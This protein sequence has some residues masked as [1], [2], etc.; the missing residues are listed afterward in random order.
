MKITKTLPLSPLL[1]SPFLTFG[2]FLGILSGC[3]TEGEPRLEALDPWARPMMIREPGGRA[4]G[5]NSAVYLALRNS[6][7]APDTLL[8][9]ETPV[10][11]AVEIHESF[12]EED[13]MRM[14]EVGPLEVPA[15]D[16]VHLKPGGLHIM[17]VDL[18]KSLVAGDTL[19]LTLRFSVSG[20]VTLRVPVQAAGSGG[21]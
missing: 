21:M 18:R 10:A 4:S 8:G 16:D 19:S 9:G 2:L 12:L 3:D 20:P 1:T 13:V 5:G 14:R 11:G 17:L 6:G 7:G 15:G